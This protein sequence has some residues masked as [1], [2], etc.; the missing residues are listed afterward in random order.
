MFTNG[1]I[2]IFSEFAYDKSK[3]IDF[4]E[5]DGLYTKEASCWCVSD[6]MRT[7]DNWDDLDRLERDEWLY[8][9]DD[10]FYRLTSKG[11]KAW[12]TL[13]SEGRI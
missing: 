7:V 11:L 5:E 4:V 9:S 6:E 2:K 13:K 12:K 8:V 1:E 3:M 10:D